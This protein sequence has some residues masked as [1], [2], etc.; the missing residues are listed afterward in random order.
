MRK[1]RVVRRI[2]GM[3]Y[4]WKGHNDR[5]RQKNRIK[6]SGQ[7][8][9]VYAKNIS[10][11][12]PT[13][14]REACG[15][16]FHRKKV[17]WCLFILIFIACPLESPSSVLFSWS[18]PCVL[19]ALTEDTPFILHSSRLVPTTTPLLELHPPPVQPLDPFNVYF[20]MPSSFVF[21]HLSHDHTSWGAVHGIFWST[22]NGQS[23]T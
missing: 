23:S 18:F 17:L 13:T 9:L 8:Q 5:N 14:W 16:L 20:S 15:D 7:A 22:T 3:K 21:I 1:R 6:R 19:Q 10:H 11:N 2:Y 4:S 12:I